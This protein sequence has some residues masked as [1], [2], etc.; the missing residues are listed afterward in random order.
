MTGQAW[1]NDRHRAETGVTGGNTV[2]S[3][4]AAIGYTDGEM[5]SVDT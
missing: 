1:R 5:T 3:K 4:Y 2:A